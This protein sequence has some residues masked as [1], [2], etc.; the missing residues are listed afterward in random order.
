MNNNN[1]ELIRR[2]LSLCTKGL[3]PFIEKEMRAVY[4]ED[5]EREAGEALRTPR[6]VRLH[7]DSQAVLNLMDRRWNEVF[8]RKLEKKHRS[9]VVEAVALRHDLMHEKKQMF[10]DKETMRGLD[11]IE[12][13]LAA[14]S[15]PESLEVAALKDTIGGT[16]SIRV[17]PPLSGQTPVRVK[18]SEHVVLRRPTAFDTDSKYMSAEERILVI[19]RIRGWASKPHLNV[20]R[21]FG[22]VVRS[23]HGVPRDDLV[24]EAARVT[25]SK[26]AYGAVASLL[27][28]KSNAYGRAL[29]D[30]YGI[31]RLHPAVEKEIRAFEWL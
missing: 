13:L 29:E 14:I 15:A 9:W 12:C 1:H 28:S 4:G 16:R 19:R 22:I 23:N 26:N 27:T 31:I 3:R 6:D 30:V 10:S 2:G 8:K 24:A 18:T 11:T 21:I 5:W 25:N 17:E 7:W 20:H